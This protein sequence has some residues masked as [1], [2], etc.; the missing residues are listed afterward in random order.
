[1]TSVP[2][3]PQS[4][5][6]QWVCLTGFGAAVVTFLGLKS[7]SVAPLHIAV[8]CIAAV[9]LSIGVL[10]LIFLK[11]HRRA[12]SGLEFDRPFDFNLRRV[13]IKLLGLLITLEVI[14]MAY[15]ILP[16]YQGSFYQHLWNMLAIYWPYLLVLVV[17]YF[18]YIDARMRDPQDGYWQVGCLLLGRWRECDAAVLRQY[19]LGWVVK[20]FFFPL[21]FTYLVNDFTR[22]LSFTPASLGSTVAIYDFLFLLT[23]SVDVLF[24]AMGYL[25][26]LRL[27][28][29]HIR[30]TEP[31][32]I[33]WS[34]AIVCYQPMWSFFSSHYLVYQDG[35][36]WGA[37]LSGSQ[38]LLVLWVIM[39]SLLNLV[40]LWSTVT[41]GVRFSNL[42]H[43]GILT[44]GPYRFSKHPAYIAKNL[45]WW[46]I[47]VPFLPVHGWDTAA[48]QCA[49]LL[50]LNLVYYLRAKTEE[51]HL[52]WDKTYVDYAR[53]M[54]ENGI[55]SRLAKRLPVLGYQEKNVLGNLSF[56]PV[57]ETSK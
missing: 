29:A 1:M 43:R 48:K 51:R 34:V 26:T 6:V 17:V 5:T 9:A 12:D 45:S 50:G 11:V 2:E 53:W 36:A 56:S 31:T 18:A 13:L 39:I 15:W 46:L 47:A 40:Y 10:D 33:G 44:N 55:F 41:F 54:N 22:L 49:M 19:A 27:F 32:L 38:A 28:G 37:W 3:K 35:Y 42:T 16:E 8:A 20:A 57:K 23:F 21:M 25:M 30:S 7:M 52:S 4:A 24:A 14:A